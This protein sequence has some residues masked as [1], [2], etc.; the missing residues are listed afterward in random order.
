[1]AGEEVEY[2]SDPEETKL[3]LK[4]RRRVASDDEEE[5]GESR[6]EKPIRRIDDSEGESEGAAAEYE[7]ELDED[8]EDYEEDED[9]VDEEIEE[10]GYQERGNMR[11]G[12]VE[13]DAERAVVGKVVGDGNTVEGVEEEVAEV[14][15]DNNVDGGEHE[16]EKKVIEPYAVPTAGAFYMHDDRFRDNAG[17][18]HRRMLGGRKLWESKDERKWGHDK[19]EELTVQERRYEERRRGSRGGRYR[20]RGRNRGADNENARGNRSREYANNSSQTN[21]HLD[22][23]PKGGVR[24]RGP[25]RSGKLVDNPSFV[26]SERASESASN[27]EPSV[28]NPRKQVF[29][30]NLSIASPPF[31]PSGSS[32]KDNT[33]P[34]KKD[35]H[36]GSIN[37]NGL[38]SVGDGNFSGPQS[39]A[40]LRGKSI[41]NSIGVDKLSIDDSFSMVPAKPSNN[42]HMP[43]SSSPSINP[44]QPQVRGHGRGIPSLTQVAYRPHTVPNNQPNRVPPPGQLQAVPRNPVQPR[45]QSSVGQQFTRV[46][47]GSQASSPPRA[48]GVVNAYEPGEL[49]SPSEIGKSKNLLVAK[50]KGNLQGSVR[51][52]VIGAS[53]NAQGDQN[54][55]S[56]LPFMQFGGQHPGGMGVPAVGMAFPG[57]VGQP[58]LGGNS[59][60]T[61]LPVLAGPA[62]ALGASYCPPYFSV[63]GSYHTRPSGQSTSVISASSNENNAA[64]VVTDLKPELRHEQYLSRTVLGS[65]QIMWW[66]MENRR[67]YFNRT[68]LVL[69]R[70]KKLIFLSESQSKQWLTWCQEENIHLKTE[71][72]LVPLSVNDE[73]AFAAGI[74]CSLNTPSFTPEKMLEKRQLLR[75]AVRKEMGLTDEDM[76]LITLSSINPGKGQFLLLE[77]ARMLLEQGQMLNDSDIK[78][79]TAIDHDYYSR[80]LLQNW[81]NVAGST[82]ESSSV[83]GSS[84]HQSTLRKKYKFLPKLVTDKNKSGPLVF[85]RDAGMRKQ[86]LESV[87]E[88]K[89]NLKIL[90][91]SVGSKS[92]KARYVKTLLKYLSVHSKVSES[93]LWTP[94][95]TRVA[96]LYAAAD[97]YVMNSQ[98]IGETF[99]RVT[100]EAMAFGLPVLGTDSG[101]TKEIVEHNITGLLH[102]V[103]RPG[104]QI[105]ARNLEFLLQNPSA[106]REM[107]TKGRQKVKKMYL[108]KHMY[109]KFGEV[110]YS[111]MR[112]K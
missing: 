25:R 2:E 16:G 31:Y 107:G 7:D 10:A 53:G 74:P 77:S 56:F 105:L 26:S 92:N 71:P 1:M 38:P 8:E 6:R 28:V 32:I 17:G 98:G 58:Q 70:V 39:S 13:V 63:D 80:A 72:A 29:A 11:D 19:F 9:Y 5:E 61:W 50:G 96:S 35:V 36:S 88:K 109:Q 15:G 27:S 51:A 44:T 47:S 94:T 23:P 41:V 45:S 100:I 84:L 55:P 97:V 91:G 75:S 102:R 59:E 112:I 76:L 54:F 73:L 57:Y 111:S 106:R 65:S 12:A 62:G 85:D 48:A 66:I 103:G 52:H 68:K 95:T 90:I 110:L 87:E 93:V 83:D 78:D 30:S 101:G 69:N 40:M 86:L 37:R 60:M 3:S 18:R 42:M 21:N 67:E 99:G 24:G 14:N 34:D 4:M 33:V 81:K 46:P 104:A 49:E 82:N 79:P 20:G 22:N 108:K 89:Q 43:V 64:K